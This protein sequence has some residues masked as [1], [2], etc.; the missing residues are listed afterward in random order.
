MGEKDWGPDDQEAQICCWG[1]RDGENRDAH[2][3]FENFPK[4]EYGKSK[5]GKDTKMMQEYEYIS[6]EIVS[7]HLQFS[8]FLHFNLIV[9]WDRDGPQ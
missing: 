2:H 1:G 6:S 4:V 3:D 8:P 5:V 9:L 7:K